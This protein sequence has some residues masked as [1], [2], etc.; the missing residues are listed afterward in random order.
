VKAVHALDRSATVIG[1]K[2][3]K[4]NQIKY[5]ERGYLSCTGDIGNGYKK[6][7][8]KLRGIC[9]FIHKHVNERMALKCIL[10]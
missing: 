9:H 1:Q 3:D 8:E 6:L 7:A 2:F 5:S 4:V 10:K